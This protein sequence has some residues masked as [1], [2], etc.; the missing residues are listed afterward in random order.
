MAFDVNKYNIQYM[1]D[2]YDRI[3]VFVPKGEKE[4]IQAYAD[5]LGVSM[6]Q[7]FVEAIRSCLGNE[8][9]LA[10]GEYRSLPLR[11]PRETFG[12]L[13][14][15]A[16]YRKRSV[17]QYAMLSLERQLQ[18]DEDKM[19]ETHFSPSEEREKVFTP[20]VGHSRRPKAPVKKGPRRPAEWPPK[21]DDD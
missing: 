21:F 17:S 1:K 19:E 15:C 8:E 18:A 11:L 16:D 4:K 20:A 9:L 14:K 5:S 3:A 2:N 6:N 7:L 10:D 12:R 13:E